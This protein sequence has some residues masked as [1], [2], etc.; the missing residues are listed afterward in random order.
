VPTVNIMDIESPPSTLA[1]AIAKVTD[2]AKRVTDELVL[3]Q[4]TRLGIDPDYVEFWHDY[5]PRNKGKEYSPYAKFYRDLKSNKRIMVASGLPMVKALGHKIEVGWLFA[6]GKYYSK[7]NLFSAIVDGKQ[8]KLSCLS[9]QPNGTKKG[10]QVTWRPQL[11]VDG[12]EIISGEP[13]LLSTDPVNENYRENVLEWTY[14][15]VAKRRIRIIEGRF[16]ERW[17]FETNPHSRVKIKANFVGSL[18]LRLGYTRDAEGNP[19][20]VSVIGDEEIVEASEFAKAVYPVEIG[21]TGTYYPDAHPE[22]SSVDGACRNGDAGNPLTWDTLHDATSGDEAQDEAADGAFI[23]YSSHADADKWKYMRRGFF[24]FD[25]SALPDDA[26]ILVATLSIYGGAVD[27]SPWNA[28]VKIY[29]SSPA[30][31]DDLILD[32]FDAVG[33]TPFCDT[34]IS[35]GSWSIA[36]YND[37]SLNASGI[38]AISKTGVSKFSARDANWDVP[39]IEPTWSDPAVSYIECYYAERGNGFKPKLVV[40]YADISITDTEVNPTYAV[41][42]GGGR[43]ALTEMEGN[44]TYFGEGGGGWNVFTETELSPFLPAPQVTTDPALWIGLLSATLDSTL[45]SGGGIQPCDC[46]FEWGETEA[47]GNTTPTERKETGDSFSQLI[48]GLLPNTT[49]HFRAF[50]TGFGT[51]Y[52]ADRTFTTAPAMILPTVTSDPA[53]GRGAIAATINGTLS[54]DGGE[55]CEC[56]FEWGLDTGYGTTTPPQSKTTGETFSQVIG[57]LVPNTTYHFRAFATNS[58]GTSYGA[59]RTFTTA[60]VISKAFALARE[61]L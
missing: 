18:K 59:D 3:K 20:K 28:L 60:L 61:E 12:S 38:A 26:L 19:V 48:T 15:N 27:T 6:K 54:Q 34:G 5:A 55:A 14:G 43:R 29:A 8:V 17:L 39:D 7:A 4:L 51:S 53:T 24:L 58:V 1:L 45:D 33:T 41:G 44:P 25:T 52:G 37:F 42:Y 10:E 56:G 36:G 49:Y 50:A 32:D 9:D 31:N 16:R 40:T 46:G 21:A 47:Y 22:T 23:Y 30:N 35:A 11:F 13:T 57:G 2:P